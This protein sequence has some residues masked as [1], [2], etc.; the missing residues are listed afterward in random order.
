MPE[1]KPLFILICVVAAV[2]A[3][4]VITL[5]ATSLKRIET[6]EVGI[7]YDNVAKELGKETEYE[8]LHN[9]PPGF[10]FIIFPSVY[11]TMQFN[12]ITCLNKDGII[13]E[14]DVSYQF[15][16]NPKHLLSLIKQ[17]VDFDGYKKV[18]L[19]SGKAAVHDTC[20]AFTTQGFQTD[21]GRFQ[22]TLR[23]IMRDYCNRFH[24]ELSDLQVNNVKRPND[25]ENAVK[26]KEAAKENIKVA[27]NERPRQ[28]LQAQTVLEKA[29]KEAEILINAAKSNVQILNN[30][31]TNEAQA[32]KYLY[33]KDLEIYIKVKNSQNLSNEGLIS[34]IGIRAIANAKNDVNLAMQSPAR[35][36]YP[37]I[38][39]P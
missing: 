31:A 25:Y 29:Y 33:D 3:V 11:E 18:L 6:K 19:A 10:Y 1:K 13:I 37:A 15:K 4:L 36:S 22:E 38:N 39:D 20:A 28:I 24:C 16:A 21:R 34:Y 35:T 7:R 32:L 2:I 27:T 30:K 17:F 9:G 14:L 23:E 5:I 8:G 12:D 26:D